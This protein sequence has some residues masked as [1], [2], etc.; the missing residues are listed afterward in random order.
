M[1]G[2][3]GE[4]DVDTVAEVVGERATRWMS[5]HTMA[6]F[7]IVLG[8]TYVVTPLAGIRSYLVTIVP[9]AVRVLLRKAAMSVCFGSPTV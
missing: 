2:E 4:G 3:I 7:G 8:V 1:T 9:R 5:C 6:L